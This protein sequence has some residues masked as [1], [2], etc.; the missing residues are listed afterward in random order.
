MSDPKR[1]MNV[2]VAK[3]RKKNPN[4][5]AVVYDLSISA[6]IKVTK[7]LMMRSLKW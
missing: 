5:S 3:S 1:N 6:I 4:A 7:G 2:V